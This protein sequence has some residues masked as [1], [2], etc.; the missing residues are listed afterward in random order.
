[1]LTNL[2]HSAVATGLE[3]ISFH[4]NSKERQCQR[5]FNY[6]TIILISYASKVKVSH[7]RFFAIHGWYSPWNSPGEVCSWTENFQTIKLDLERSEEPEI[8]LSTSTGSQRKQESSRKTSTHAVLTMTKPL[9]V[10]IKTNCGKFLTRW[11]YQTT[12]LPP[13]KSVCRSRSES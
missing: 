12:S 1:M 4:C 13:E 8:K 6:Y 10:W 11:E 9:T 5:M 7:V 3:K 2:E